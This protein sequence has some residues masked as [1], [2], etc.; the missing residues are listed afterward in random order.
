LPAIFFEGFNDMHQLLKT[1]PCSMLLLGNE[2]IVR[3]ALEAGVRVSAAYPGTPSSEIGNNLFQIHSECPEL[4]Y[5]EFSV[6]EKVAMEVAAAAAAAGLRS[7]TC[8]K[9]VGMNVASDAMMSLAYVGVKAGMVIVC[10]DD[11]SIH[12]SQNEQ[13][14]RFYGKMSF[15][16]IL[17]PSSPQEAKDL[18]K[19]A[20]ELSE[21]LELPVILRTT[22]RTAHVRGPVQLEALPDAP[23]GLGRFQKDARRW[24]LV[25]G[26]A[27]LRRKVL[28]ER[29]EQA[30]AISEGFEFNEI[31]GSG[32]VGIVASG[33]S[34]GYVWDAL[35]DMDC[36]NQVSFLSLVM[37]HPL[38]EKTIVNFAQNKKML[39]VVEEL[40][41]FL[42]EEIR[43][44][45]QKN[46]V[47]TPVYGKNGAYL[48]RMSEFN[49]A[50]VRAAIA[51]FLGHSLV[52]QGPLQ[53]PDMPPLPMR[54]PALCKGCPHTET[55]N[56]I[57][58]VVHDLGLNEDVLYPT[59]IGCYTLGVMPPIQ[60]ADYLICMGSSVGSSAGFSVSTHQKI[61]SF[62][63]DSTFFHSGVS[64]L[65]NAVHQ[66]HRF[67]LVILD[68]STTAMTGHQPNPGIQY[69]PP[70]Y[71]K[72]RVPI[73][74]VVRGCGVQ[75]VFKINP[76]KKDESLPVVREALSLNE[77][78]VIISESPCILYAKKVG[79]RR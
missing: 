37:T 69:V 61:I 14:N 34:R 63:G 57:K 76:H 77:L 3:G 62:I 8:M 40:E 50:Q 68:N 72:T 73:E 2:A 60:M 29:F 33:V 7:L 71:K 52:Q 15:L 46:G 66:G 35:H 48:P 18:V 54:P 28:L 41:P 67:C 25:P 6:N 24:V 75:H 26:T 22:T 79:G 23:K 10:A 12:S 5:F 30:S 17:E 45:L 11:P 31:I 13:D 58:E 47:T 21:A 39:L 16:P 27:R 19:R 43:S 42:E 20:F 49:P 59:D 53:L 44:V 36:T 64:S 4:V 51:K 70:E 9:H 74:Q 32:D 65:I 38:P 78:V 56:L 55:Y 1:E